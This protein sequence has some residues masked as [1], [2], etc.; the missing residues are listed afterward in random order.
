MEEMKEKEKKEFK[1][2][3]EE[4][5]EKLGFK[6]IIEVKGRKKK[7]IIEELRRRV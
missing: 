2:L 5:K 1:E 7:E 3:K 6:L 4:Y